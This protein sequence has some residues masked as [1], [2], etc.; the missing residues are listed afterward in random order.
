MRVVSPIRGWGPLKVLQF[1]ISLAVG[2]V[3]F[4]IVLWFMSQA[5]C[6]YLL[7]PAAIMMLRN[8]MRPIRPAL[9]FGWRTAEPP[10]AERANGQAKRGA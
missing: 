9:Q 8:V 2:F 1:I 3:I 6:D 10:S 7:S 4:G 5:I